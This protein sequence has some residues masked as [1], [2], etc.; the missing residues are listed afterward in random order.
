MEIPME[1]IEDLNPSKLVNFTLLETILTGIRDW[2][3][4]PY[5]VNVLEA[6]AWHYIDTEEYSNFVKELKKTADANI[7]DKTEKIMFIAN[8]KMKF[9]IKEIMK[10]GEKRLRTL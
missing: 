1:L 8:E 9:L 2:Q 3:K 4:I 6:V 5:A 7:S 10:R